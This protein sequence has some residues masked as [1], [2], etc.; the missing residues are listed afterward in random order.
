MQVEVTWQIFFCF[1]VEFKELTC[2]ICQFLTHVGNISKFF[3]VVSSKT[4]DSSHFTLVYTFSEYMTCISEHVLVELHC[5]EFIS[6]YKL[7][8]I[9]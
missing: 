2:F 9:R 3:E 6:A 8:K 4:H 1:V 7:S 5:Y